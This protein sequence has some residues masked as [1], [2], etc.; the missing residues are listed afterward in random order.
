[1]NI[2]IYGKENCPLCEQAKKIVGEKLKF[3][4]R[5]RDMATPEGIADYCF[6]GYD[7][8]YQM[9]Y[10][11]IVIDGESYKVIGEAVKCLKRYQ[12]YPET[13]APVEEPV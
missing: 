3:D 5:Y 13:T 11:V 7:V 2:E 4:Y 12:S 1:M 6:N 9:T 10:P 8:R